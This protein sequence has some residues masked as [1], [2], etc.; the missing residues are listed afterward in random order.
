MAYSRGC[1]DLTSKLMGR[2]NLCATPSGSA[3]EGA[4]TGSPGVSGAPRTPEIKEAEMA[5]QL[6]SASE[7]LQPEGDT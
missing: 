1:A 7:P 5:T 6:P 3:A 2:N 4:C